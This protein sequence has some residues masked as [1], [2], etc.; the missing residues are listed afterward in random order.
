MVASVMFG[1]AEIEM[2]YRRERQA[3]G[4]AVAKRRGV[5]TGRKARTTKADPARAR[6]LRDRGLTVP[7][8]ATAI[9]IGDRTAF[10]CLAAASTSC[11]PLMPQVARMLG[12]GQVMGLDLLPKNGLFRKSSG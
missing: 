6:Q 3:A 2:E 7:E 4:I 9:G 10:R 1:L 5:Y 8:I 12:L 11:P